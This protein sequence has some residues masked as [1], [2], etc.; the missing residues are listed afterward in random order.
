MSE[1]IGGSRAFGRFPEL[2]AFRSW[3]SHGMLL[4]TS[5]TCIVCA[6]AAVGGLWVLPDFHLW[7]TVTFGVLSFGLSQLIRRKPATTQYAIPSFIVGL[8]VVLLSGDV[9]VVAD[10]MRFAWHFPALGAAFVIGGIAGGLFILAT[11]IL[12]LSVSTFA[13]SAMSVAGLL[14]YCTTLSLMSV[15]IVII[16]LR[17]VWTLEKLQKSRLIL[18]DLANTDPLTGLGNRLAFDRKLKALFYSGADFSVILCDLDHFKGINDTYGHAIGDDVLK[19]VATI[20]TN[21][22]RPQDMVARIGGEEFCMLLTDVGLEGALQ[23]TEAIRKEIQK[24]PVKAGS[25]LVHCTASFGVTHKG[26]A[27]R[28]DPS[29]L[30]VAADRALYAAKADGRNRLRIAA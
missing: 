26:A 27:V 16:E 28:S 25:E 22:T 10:E 23:R 30:L 4:A 1:K 8:A 3:L 20:L 7:L 14:T 9:L 29:Q 18:A 11:A 13:L 19:A 21:S 2:E 6:I 17:F 24:H 5:V 15:L 12:S